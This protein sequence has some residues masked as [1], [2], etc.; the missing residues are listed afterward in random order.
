MPGEL[1]VIELSELSDLGEVLGVDIKKETVLLAHCLT[2]PGSS[3]GGLE[4]LTKH[5]SK[6]KENLHR[7]VKDWMMTERS[8]SIE[9]SSP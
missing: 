1:L 9:K 8:L 7:E 2:P 6:Q 3:V 5:F 4:A